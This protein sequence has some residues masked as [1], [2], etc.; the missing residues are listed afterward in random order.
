MDYNGKLL[1]RA[2]ARLAEQR[3]RNAAEQR[4]RME[5]AYARLPRLRGLDRQLR[6]QMID[7]ARL[8]MAR[9]PEARESIERLKREN[10]ALQ[11]E[12]A[13][14]LAS[15]GLPADYTDEIYLSLIHI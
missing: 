5:L 6:M 8:A 12:R 10:L 13:E 9:G 14:L 15:A 2:R 11:A 1:A 7:L 3:E 4:R